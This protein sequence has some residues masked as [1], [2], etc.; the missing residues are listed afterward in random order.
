MVSNYIY[1]RP[2]YHY[3]MTFDNIK[4]LLL[5]LKVIKVINKDMCV[6][7]ADLVNCSF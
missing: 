6:V 4:E 3:L 1:Q 2:N 7:H 5:L